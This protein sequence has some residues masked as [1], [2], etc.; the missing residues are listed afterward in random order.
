MCTKLL[1]GA[2]TAV[3]FD[4]MV[5]V[6]LSPTDT[7]LVC[8]RD[9][10]PGMCIRDPITGY[11]VPLFHVCLNAESQGEVRQYLGLR[12]DPSQLVCVPEVGWVPLSFVG[13]LVD[14]RDGIA[15]L[16]TK[17]L[18]SARIDGVTCATFRAP[19]EEEWKLACERA[20]RKRR[21]AE[22]AEEEERRQA[23]RAEAKEESEE[24]RNQWD[25][26]AREE[27]EAA[28]LLASVVLSLRCVDQSVRISE[29]GGM[30]VAEY[31]HAP[32]RR[33]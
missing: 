6:A 25:V 13:T 1:P 18:A 33:R 8:V 2:M 3:S 28:P 29:R 15:C 11:A 17:H 5:E 16:L 26:G 32:R 20:R 21:E 27:V 7:T 31:G 19:S 30:R 9:L 24:N 4:S 14:S 22:R 10:A 23:E 12:A